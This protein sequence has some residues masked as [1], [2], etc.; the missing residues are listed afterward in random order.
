M[1][2]LIDIRI[3]PVGPRESGGA[4]GWVRFDGPPQFRVSLDLISLPQKKVAIA[5]RDIGGRRV[6]L[7]G[8][9][10]GRARFVGF[11]I[12]FVSGAEIQPRFCG[13]GV[14]LNRLS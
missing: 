9:D 3:G 1:E 6:A 11:S 7:L 8:L 12:Q 10:V 5:P 13:D 14:Q 4:R 2:D